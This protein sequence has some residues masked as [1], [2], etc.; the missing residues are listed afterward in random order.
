[1][2]VISN[3]EFISIQEIADTYSYSNAIL[4]MDIEGAEYETLNYLNSQDLSRFSMIVV[5]IHGLSRMLDPDVGYLQVRQ[6]IETL[7]ELHVPVHAHPNNIGGYFKCYGT[8]FPNIVELTLVRRNLAGIIGG[9]IH[10]NRE[11]DVPNSMKYP[12]LPFPILKGASI[13]E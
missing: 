7:T 1:L 2:G 9:R 10:P 4:Q 6:L 3:S 8:N 11:L 5:E 13:L 12:D